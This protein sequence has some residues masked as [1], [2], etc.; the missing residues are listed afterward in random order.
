MDSH[1]FEKLGAFY[2]GGAVDSD[3]TVDPSSSILYDAKDLTTHAVCLG[4]TG[5]GKTGLGVALIE[6]AIL[7]GV[8]VIAIDPKGD[9]GN[10]M[11]SFPKLR[12][13]DFR[14]WIDESAAL[15][16]GKDPDEQAAFLAGLWKKGLR[17][18]GQGPDRIAAYQ[19]AAEFALYTPGS[20]VGR[21]LAVLRS[22]DAP[23][24]ATRD[25]AEALRDRVFGCVAGLLGYVGLEAD[26]VKSRETILLCSI[27]EHA[28]TQGQSLDLP[29]LIRAVQDPPVTQIGVF[30]LDTFYPADDRFELAMKLNAVL[31]SAGASAWTRGEALDVQSLFF[32]S[33]GKPRLSVLSLG[34]LDERERMFFVTLL[35]NEVLAWSRAQPGTGTLRAILYMDE[36]YGYLPP[37]ANPPS[38]RPLLT[39]LKQARASGLGLVLATQN[40]V[41]LDYKALSNIGTWFLGRLQTERDKERVLEGLE[42]LGDGA[43]MPRAELDRTL[44]NLDSRVFLMRNVH[45]DAPTLMHVRWVLNYLAG[46][47][48]KEQIRKLPESIRTSPA[49]AEPV[50]RPAPT[51]VESSA[52][53]IGPNIDPD[54]LQLHAA[55]T[56]SGRLVYRAAV[57]GRARLHYANARAKVDVWDEVTL[58]APLSEDL[59]ADVWES[60]EAFDAPRSGWSDDPL[61]HSSYAPVPSDAT[62]AKSFT[63]WSKQLK[64]ALYRDR[65]LVLSSCPGLKLVSTPDE[66]EGAFRARVNERVRELRDL[67]VEKLRTKTAPKLARLEQRI[68]TAEERVDRERA[69]RKQKAL[70]TAVSLGTTVLGA[71]FGRKRSAV[72]RAGSTLR[73]AS[74]TAKEGGDVS[75]A[76]EKVED[77]QSQ[78]AALNEEMQAELDAIRD[79]VVAAN[80]EIEEKR[81]SPRKSDLD[82]VEIGLL[83]LP[84]R[85]LG[86]GLVERAW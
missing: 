33:D 59:P 22:L 25:D 47:M 1:A 56:G 3:G 20:E 72:T 44:S 12:A 67:R 2:L 70:D 8:P 50:T 53:S 64:S 5:S 69:Q 61:P 82:V 13:A 77:L 14:P 43:G 76:Q 79:E 71:F 30:D 51:A 35:M 21:P 85:V 65:P 81:L 15:R 29:S 68:R 75:R 42:S 52:S 78:L 37:V 63:A 84:H 54:V 41:D 10:L 28:W 27:L 62:K 19:D 58:V 18:W 24:A 66:S 38:K 60:A 6:E 9:L 7:D 32:A 45:D 31:A 11:L 26:P 57:F 48:T 4:M 34:H 16:D 36:V 46:P 86:D 73:A 80:Y 55:P 83:W 40:P 39:L 23:S 74:R 17:E 49:K